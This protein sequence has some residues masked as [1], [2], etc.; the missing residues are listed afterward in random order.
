[1]AIDKNAGQMVFED[2]INERPDLC[3]DVVDWYL[4]SQLEI[5]IKLSSGQKILYDYLDKTIRIPR[6]CEDD[7]YPD[8][9]MWSKSFGKQLDRKIK[10]RGFSRSEFAERVGLSQPQLSQYINGQVIPSIYIT[11]KMA[12]ALECSVSEL[13]WYK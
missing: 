7:E 12:A 11:A 8:K 5:T 2:F 13:A 3:D 1:M 4:S 10:I 9:N 6:K